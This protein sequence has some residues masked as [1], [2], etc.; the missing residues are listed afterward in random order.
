MSNLDLFSS[1]IELLSKAADAPQQLAALRCALG[2]AADDVV[3]ERVT[4]GIAALEG[5]VVCQDRI[6]AIISILEGSQPSNESLDEVKSLLFELSN[7]YS[8]GSPQNPEEEHFRRI[9]G[10]RSDTMGGMLWDLAGDLDCLLHPE[11]YNW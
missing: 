2:N 9:F 1:C 4:R 11:E 5:V 7:L 10:P 3:R 6:R 8:D